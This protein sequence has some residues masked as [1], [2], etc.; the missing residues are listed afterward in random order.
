MSSLSE[1]VIYFFLLLL[2]KGEFQ[3]RQKLLADRYTSVQILYKKSG[4]FLEI[5]GKIHISLDFVWQT[6]DS[7]CT[8]LT[9]L[10]LVKVSS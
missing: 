4:S 10:K 7:Y 3:C 5:Y 9:H 6:Y 1:K 8:S 2:R